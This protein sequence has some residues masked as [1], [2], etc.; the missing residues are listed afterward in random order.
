M[1]FHRDNTHLNVG[2]FANPDPENGGKTWRVTAD[3]I[4]DGS[5]HLIGWLP[6]AEGL[7]RR[8]ALKIKNEREKRMR[9]DL[10]SL[11]LG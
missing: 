4:T 9:K 5:G 8:K 2:F 6:V 1:I 7:T 10:A 3:H 11:R